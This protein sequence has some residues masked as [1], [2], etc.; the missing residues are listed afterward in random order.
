MTR[1]AQKADGVI[2]DHDVFD[3]GA[4]NDSTTSC[5]TVEVIAAVLGTQDGAIA[6]GHH[7]L[8]TGVLD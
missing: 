4:V 7:L 8:S 1:E 2:V 3:V 5:A 6:S